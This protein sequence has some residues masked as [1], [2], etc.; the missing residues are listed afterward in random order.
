MPALRET[1]EQFLA[2]VLG[3]DPRAAAPW[4]RRRLAVYRMNAREN[5]SGALEAAFPLLH[6]LMGHE[7]FRAMAWAFQRACP[8]GS[9]NLFHCGERLPGFLARHLAGTNDASLAIVSAFEW[10]IQQV[11]VAGDVPAGPDL[12]LLAAVPPAQHRALCCTLHPAF[13][14]WQSPLPLFVLWDEYQRTGQ[15]GRLEVPERGPGQALLIRRAAG[16]VEL[17]RL[18]GPE[19]RF[20][21]ALADD[22]PL[23][24][25]FAAALIGGDAEASADRWLSRWVRAGLITG[26]VLPAA[27][28]AGSRT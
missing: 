27:E 22:A 16:G 7:E 26:F 24:A 28:A 6:G 17:E 18:P 20:L 25:A 19:Y 13:R 9:G 4:P 23:A 21:L 8:S 14:L 2:A 10:L 15:V 11:L 5:F 12:A 1:Q 3:R